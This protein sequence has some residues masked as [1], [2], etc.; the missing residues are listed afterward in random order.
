[1]SEAIVIIVVWMTSICLMGE[2]NYVMFGISDAT[3]LAIA[4]YVA[5]IHPIA[6]KI[7][8]TKTVVRNTC[9]CIWMIILWETLVCYFGSQVTV[10]EGRFGAVHDLFCRELVSYTTRNITASSR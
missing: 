1:L 4:R 10:G 2:L 7:R 8:R 6:Y 3:L 5:I 9:T